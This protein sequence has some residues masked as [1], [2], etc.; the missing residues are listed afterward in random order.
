MHC[1]TVKE[2]LWAYLKK[3][4]TAE[5]AVKIEEHL[6]GC[7][8]C[9]EEYDAQ[10]EILG[11]LSDLPEEELP[12]GYHAELMQK[13][14][15]EAKVVPITA[16][17]KKQPIWKQW[18]MIAAAI[19]MVIAAGG[20]EG[21]LSMREGQQAAVEQARM[22]Q[23]ADTSTETAEDAADAEAL[24]DTAGEISTENGKSAGAGVGKKTENAGRKAA[25][26]QRVNE[27]ETA[28]DASGDIPETAAETAGME[29]IMPFSG[30]R[31][32]D[33]QAEEFVIIRTADLTAAKTIVREAITAA[34]G[35]E[36]VTE[37]EDSMIAVIPAE[38]FVSFAAALEEIGGTEWIQTTDEITSEYRCIEIELI[39]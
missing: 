2:M 17:K 20:M 1:E 31:S 11:M 7:A 39:Q 13:I 3:E 16:K 19:L 32:V 6:A 30:K 28:Y 9:R 22:M 18:G 4:T 34:E 15:A 10:K 21:L 23:A 12:E 14:Q 33:T 35:Y 26:T 37:A 38:S 24:V 5:E 36:E 8:A 25:K 29:G 27:A